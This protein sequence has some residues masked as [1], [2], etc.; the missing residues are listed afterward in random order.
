MCRKMNFRK[1]IRATVRRLHAWTESR[2]R[3]VIAAMLSAV[4]VSVGYRL[5]VPG[6][7]TPPARPGMEA[8]GNPLTDG[9]SGIAAT[10]SMLGEL[11]EL[12][13]MAGTLSARDTLGEADSLLLIEMLGRMDELE[14]R[15]ASDYQKK[16]HHE[17]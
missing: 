15:L 2:Q 10:A 14:K 12:Q 4:V 9:F 6:E 17:D 11:L 1:A 3:L 13:A 8:G 5:T 7:R 16:N